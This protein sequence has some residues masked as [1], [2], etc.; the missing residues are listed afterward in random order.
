MVA[1]KEN[2][3]SKDNTSK[4]LSFA[5]KMMENILKQLEAN[6]KVKINDSAL[7]M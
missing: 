4:A 6:T 3:T 7:R 1:E 2:R 5:R